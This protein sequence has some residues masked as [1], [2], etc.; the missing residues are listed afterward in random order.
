MGNLRG[1]VGEVVTAWLLLRHFMVESSKL[2]SEDP[3]TDL[4]NKELAF[5]WLLAEKLRND[6]IGRLSELCLSPVLTSS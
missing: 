3:A 5:L 4:A 1:E 2:R 6:L